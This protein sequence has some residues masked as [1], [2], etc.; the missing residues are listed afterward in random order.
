MQISILIGK[1]EFD[2][3]NHDAFLDEYQDSANRIFVYLGI[4]FYDMQK[5]FKNQLER[6]QQHWQDKI[7]SRYSLYRLC[8]I[9]KDFQMES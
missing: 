6:D 3:I 9:K 1:Y 7:Y 8:T 4:L 5:T 2:I